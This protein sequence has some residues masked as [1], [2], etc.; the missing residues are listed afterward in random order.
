M[1]TREMSVRMLA[2]ASA[3]LEDPKFGRTGGGEPVSASAL[4]EVE[5]LVRSLWRKQPDISLDS[6]V[7]A[8]AELPDSP[9][10]RR[11]RGFQEQVRALV[12]DSF[13]IRRGNRR[14]GRREIAS[15]VRDAAELVY[16]LAWLS[17]LWTVAREVCPVKQ[18]EAGAARRDGGGPTRE[19][20]SSPLGPEARAAQEVAAT[21]PP[22]G[23]PKTALQL[24]WERALQGKNKGKK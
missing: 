19:R 22:E 8:L 10:A 12:Q 9:L 11:N 15:G 20:P 14:F 24:A 5:R 2:L 17:R 13:G 21:A 7:Q 6:L 23:A 1:A 16:L 18:P 3:L 4:A